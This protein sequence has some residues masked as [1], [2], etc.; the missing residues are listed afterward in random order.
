[1]PEENK[2][3]T[4]EEPKAKETKEETKKVEPEELE[5]KGEKQKPSVETEEK[6]EKEIEEKEPPKRF[7][8]QEQ[9][10]LEKRIGYIE[11]KLK[12]KEEAKLEEID[13]GEDEEEKPVTRRELNQLLE[14]QKKELVSN[15]MVDQFLDENPDFKKYGKVIRKYASDS[16]YANIPIGSIASMIVGEH[17][18]E[19]ANERAKIK[20][21]ADQEAAKTKIGGSSKRGFPSTKKVWDMTPK[22]F[23]EYQVEILKKGRD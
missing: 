13:L 9:T 14:Q 21:E 12:E 11:R 2:E 6:E 19:E 23:E 4:L 3:K 8:K 1:M 7:P 22:E 20:I 16:D 17:L 18:D 5:E 10:P 15:Q